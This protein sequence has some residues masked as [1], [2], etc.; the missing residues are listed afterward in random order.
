MRTNGRAS[1]RHRLRLLT[2]LLTVGLIAAAC[3]DGGDGGDGG[4]ESGDTSE[5]GESTETSDEGEGG[6]SSAGGDDIL[7][8]VVP[9]EPRTLASWNAYSNDG[10]PVLRNVTEALLNRDPETSELVPELATSWEQTSDDT[11]QFTL[12]EGVTFHDGSEFNAESA[13]ASIN[14]VL[15]EENAFPMRQFLGSELE[16]TVVDEY[17]ID[18]VTEDPD[19]ILPLRMYFVTIPSAQ[20]IEESP[21]TYETDPVGTG[22]YQLS[23]WN[24]GTSISLTAYEDWWGRSDREAAHGSNEVFSQADF[25]FRSESEVR[26]S[27]LGTGE[28]DFA[29]WL[30]PE[31]CDAA[32]QCVAGPSVETVILRVDTPHPT[33]ADERVREAISLAFD[34]SVIMDDIM[35]GGELARQI[36]SSSAVGYNEDLEPYPYDP[37]RAT[38]LIDQA[39]ADGID[40]DAE[41]TVAAREGFVLRADESVQVIAEALRDVGLTGVTSAMQETGAYE[42]QW[43]AGY[44]NISPDRGLIGLHSHGN[45]LMDYAASFGS[46]YACGGAVSAFCDEEGDAMYFE[47]IQYA[48]EERQEALAELAAFAHE[49]R[50]ITPIGHPLFYFGVQEGLDWTQRMDGFIL[51][52]E[53]DRN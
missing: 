52:K 37:E 51:V 19:P 48:E 2:V 33:L 39:R 14:Y 1:K 17:T 28:A 31:Q 11:W 38:E 21:D 34:K 40:V 49:S 16:A 7:T 8:L 15:S 9:E 36:V 42:D 35:G 41:L 13:A 32:A 3:G 12:R 46:Y 23:E 47:A 20:A 53:F 22:P 18:L 4:D 29:R 5:E 10:H 25:L 6:E 43:T 30:T 45:E 44:A 27:M 50:A 24:R 26:A